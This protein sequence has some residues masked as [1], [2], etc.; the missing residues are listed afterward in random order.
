MTG[1]H[2]ADDR[3]VRHDLQVRAFVPGFRP[4]QTTFGFVYDAQRPSQVAI[5]LGRDALTGLHGWL[6][7]ARVTLD[8]GR[9]SEMHD[10]DGL[11]TVRPSVDADGV[12]RPFE[13]TTIEGR[14]GDTAIA[15]VVH[16]HVL[17]PFVAATHVLVAP[18]EEGGATDWDAE[19]QRLSTC[20]HCGAE[21]GSL[22]AGCRT[23]A[24]LKRESDIDFLISSTYDE[25]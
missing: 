1:R 15:I 5:D 6:R 23:P 2:R 17:D 9:F 16:R 13:H 24:C 8:R 12:L 10:P 3:A 25:D 19:M 4:L 11:T 7:F 18:E 22:L 14:D 21:V 20:P